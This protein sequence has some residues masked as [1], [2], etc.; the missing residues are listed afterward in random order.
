MS[1][2]E[3]KEYELKTGE[4]FIVRTAVPDDAQALLEYVPFGCKPVVWIKKTCVTNQ[5]LGKL[6]AVYCRM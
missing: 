1:E 2:I 5:V 4:K 6:S 3:P